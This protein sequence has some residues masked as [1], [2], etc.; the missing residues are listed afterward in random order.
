MTTEIISDLISD[1][2]TARLKGTDFYE[3]QF[4][5]LNLDLEHM[6]KALK[7]CEESAQQAIWDLSLEIETLDRDIEGIKEI[8]A[9]AQTLQSAYELLQG[10]KIG[11]EK[12]INEGRQTQPTLQKVIVESLN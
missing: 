5:A 4:E 1:F 10:Y 12:T 6:E 3:G 8:I 2:E 11:L 7:I 9:R